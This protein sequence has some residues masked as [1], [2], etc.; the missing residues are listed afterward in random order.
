MN[1]LRK[2]F[3]TVLVIILFLVSSQALAANCPSGYTKSGNYCCNN[4]Y[5]EPAGFLV[6]YCQA[7]RAKCEAAPSNGTF[8]E[9]GTKSTCCYKDDSCGVSKNSGVQTAV[10][11]PPKPTAANC[12]G[13]STLLEEKTYDG[14]PVWCCNATEERGALVDKYPTYPYCQPKGVAGS[15][16][17]LKGQTGKIAKGTA[18]TDYANDKRCCI[19]GSIP[20]TH[21]NGMPYCQYNAKTAANSYHLPGAPWAQLSQAINANLNITPNNPTPTP[22]TNPVPPA[23]GSNSTP[24]ANPVRADLVVNLPRG[25]EVWT[26][27]ATKEINWSETNYK[28]SP[29]LY[30]I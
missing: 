18:G 5:E 23:T 28:Y 21:P 29:G 11:I 19:D 9:A 30:K 24:A 2:Y 26:I 27:G 13:G 16:C 17:K 4:L 8:C 20:N 15:A 3:Y 22:P 12:P 1:K 6:G 10:C 25:G 14:K 7:I